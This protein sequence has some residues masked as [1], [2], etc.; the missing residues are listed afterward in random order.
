MAILFF[1]KVL[2]YYPSS[3]VERRR[4][5]SVQ[6]TSAL[7]MDVVQQSHC[8]EWRQSLRKIRASE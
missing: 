7:I 2:Q 3:L 5:F 4:Q 1:S 8:I 6:P